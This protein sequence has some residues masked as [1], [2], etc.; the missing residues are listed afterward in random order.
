[1]AKSQEIASQSFGMG[2]KHSCS[3]ESSSLAAP[4]AKDDSGTAA[5]SE[6]VGDGEAHEST[7]KDQD[8][9]FTHG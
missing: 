1:L 6:L 5:P 9:L 3:H 2:S 4:P 8:L 7:T